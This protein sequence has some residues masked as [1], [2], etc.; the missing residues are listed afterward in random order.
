M[1]VTSKYLKVYSKSLL[2]WFIPKQT[3]MSLYVFAVTFVLSISFNA[4]AQVDVLKFIHEA[5]EDSTFILIFAVVSALVIVISGFSPKKV[6]G[7]KF[8]S[9]SF[10]VFAN[11]ILSL[12]YFYYYSEQSLL[13][14]K[15]L[16]TYHL[17]TGVVVVILYRI[18]GD[19]F[20]K[21]MPY[22][23]HTSVIKIVLANLLLLSVFI[24][25]YKSEY[26][27]LWQIPITT[28]MFLWGI[29]ESVLD[30]FYFKIG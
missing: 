6:W 8:F 7:Q 2:D 5:D 17:V 15:L 18:L 12:A 23:F 25:F 3:E 20:D 16:A 11:L 29:I 24:F 22:V 28:A 19:E 4:S 27:V 14:M 30:K 26:V 10:F 21:R 13:T 9:S 1:S